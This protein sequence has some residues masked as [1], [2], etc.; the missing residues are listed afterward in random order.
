MWKV[1]LF[2]L[3][4]DDREERAVSD[5]IKSGWITMGQKTIDFETKFAHYLGEDVKCTAVSSCTAALHMA[6]MALDVKS[7]DEVI[8]PALTFIAGLNVVTISGATP[9]LA[10]CTSYKNWNIDPEDIRKKITK[11][12]KAIM[13]VHFAGYPCDMDEILKIC[14]EYNLYLIEDVAHAPGGEF[15]GKKLGT[16]GDISC[17]SFFTNKNLSVG[18]GGMFV[19]KFDELGKNGRLLRSHGMS[20]PTLDRFKGR[21]ITYD[22]EH[23]GV[24]YRIDEMRAA[25]GLVQLE[26]LE[27]ANKQRNELVKKYKE[28]LNSIEGIEIPFDYDFEGKSTYHIFP[29]LLGIGIDRVKIIS[30][31]KEEGVQSSIHYPAFSDFSAYHNFNSK[32]TPIASEISSR[33]LTLP[34]YPTMTDNDIDT[35]V[36]ALNKA[37]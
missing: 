10:D 29:V 9:V 17:F 14:K 12:T 11:R 32:D 36:D 28:R 34:L 22:I 18:E 1:Q 26:K 20:S 25:L 8:V 27:N 24:N 33:E 23:P 21:A 37:L 3:N 15:K 35:V 5:V 31:L 13:I 7:G 30:I 2:K 4:Y 19:T 6:L 16:F